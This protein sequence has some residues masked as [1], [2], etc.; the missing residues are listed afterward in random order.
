ML[1]L[2]NDACCFLKQRSSL[3]TVIFTHFDFCVCLLFA[4]PLVAETITAHHWKLNIPLALY[5]SLH[6]HLP[7]LPSAFPQRTT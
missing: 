6:N 5:S 7:Q 3:S 4:K 2:L 1:V